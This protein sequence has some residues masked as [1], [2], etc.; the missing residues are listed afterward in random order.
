[1]S[2]LPFPLHSRQKSIPYFCGSKVS[3]MSVLKPPVFDASIQRTSKIRYSIFLLLAFFPIRQRRYFRGL[4]VNDSRC[5]SIPE[6][7]LRTKLLLTSAS[8]AITLH[9]ETPV[10]RPPFPH[11][12]KRMRDLFA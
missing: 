10:S 4:I 12:G 8:T 3:S 1:L 9:P 6:M 2:N 5:T 11:V 7:F